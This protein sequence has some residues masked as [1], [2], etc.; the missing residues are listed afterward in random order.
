[1]RWCGFP[2]LG[3]TQKTHPAH[4][5]GIENGKPNRAA[6]GPLLGDTDHICDTHDLARNA[7][8][9]GQPQHGAEMADDLLRLIELHGG[10]RIAAV[11]VEPVAG[12]TGVLVPPIG[13]LERLR[14]ICDGHGICRSHK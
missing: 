10:H 9:R 14:E 4:R 12:S 7:F 8:S 2:E 11:M 1:M 6:F 5:T 3:R 13:Y